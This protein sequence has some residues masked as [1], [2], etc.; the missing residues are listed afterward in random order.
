V[1]QIYNKAQGINPEWGGLKEIPYRVFT[2][3][4]LC[5]MKEL[6]NLQFHPYKIYEQAEV[7]KF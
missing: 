2:V 4:N 3:L 5:T 1:I 6:M 7:Q